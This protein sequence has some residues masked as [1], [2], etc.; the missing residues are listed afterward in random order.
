MYT[1][2]ITPDDYVYLCEDPDDIDVRLLD[3]LRV[4]GD[5]GVSMVALVSELEM[6]ER[7]IYDRMVTWVF[8]GKAVILCSADG[9]WQSCCS[10]GRMTYRLAQNPQEVRETARLMKDGVEH[11]NQIWGGL[12]TIASRMEGNDGSLGAEDTDALLEKLRA[13]PAGH[14]LTGSEQVCGPASLLEQAAALVRKGEPICIGLSEDWA[15]AI[16]DPH[17]M[18]YFLATEPSEIEETIEWLN[19]LQE[20]LGGMASN[21]GAILERTTRDGRSP[22]E[23]A[24]EECQLRKKN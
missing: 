23:A 20:L 4:A 6:D 8:R 12:E 10:P 24:P 22:T 16:L 21:L 14:R 19:E 9:A 11:L 1:N 5:E 2:P 3:R 18:G 13:I 15:A 17:W 7:S